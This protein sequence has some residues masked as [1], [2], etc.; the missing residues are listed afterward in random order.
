MILTCFCLTYWILTYK[1]I[2]LFENKRNEDFYFLTLSYV[3]SLYN[4]QI[5]KKNKLIIIYHSL[6]LLFFVSIGMQ[7]MACTHSLALYSSL[8]CVLSPFHITL[9]RDGTFFFAWLSGMNKIL[10]RVFFIINTTKYSY[11][12]FWRKILMRK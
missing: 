12:H 6:L 10:I 5:T 2:Y 11:N 8:L 4:H 1:C 9:L 7:I 3:W